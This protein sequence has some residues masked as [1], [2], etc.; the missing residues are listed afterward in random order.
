MVWNL[1]VVYKSE[2]VCSRRWQG[3]EEEVG[4]G[5]RDRL[6]MIEPEDCSHFKDVGF[7]SSKR[8]SSCYITFVKD[9]SGGCA[10][11]RLSRASVPMR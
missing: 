5:L 1:Q 8:S 10:V 3:T 2:P 6:E 9:Y 11:G 4:E 7:T